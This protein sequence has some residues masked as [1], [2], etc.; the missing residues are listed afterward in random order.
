MQPEPTGSGFLQQACHAE[1]SQD[2]CGLRHGAA[3]KGGNRVR[4]EITR[5]ESEQ[6][7][8]RAAGR[9]QTL[10]RQVERRAHRVD[11]GELATLAHLRRILRDAR[12]RLHAQVGRG[13][14]QHQRQ[15]P[16]DPGEFVDGFSLGVGPF[17]A[18]QLRHQRM[19]IRGFE[20]VEADAMGAVRRRE[21]RQPV[22]AGYHD[23]AA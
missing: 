5:R 2:I 9:F 19:R 1:L 12:M 11:V 22:P 4:G 13:D 14:P 8:D 20:G 6:R 7:E 15:V 16:A 17:G 18:D 21:V 3:G 10:E 23:E